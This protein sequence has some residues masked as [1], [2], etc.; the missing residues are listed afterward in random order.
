M[1]R[2]NYEPDAAG[3]APELPDPAQSQGPIPPPVPPHGY[4][5]RDPPFKSTAFSVIL[6]I[7][8]PGLGHIYVGY[9]R[10]AFT[11]ILIM[12]SLITLLAAGDMGGLVPLL[13]IMLGFTYFYQIIDA[14]RRASLYNHVLA[15]GQVGLTA[16]NIELPETNPRFGGGVLIAIGV[17]AL[18]NTL[19]DISLDWLADW[20]PLALIILGG[21]M[22]AKGRETPGKTSAPRD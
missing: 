6:A 18:G 12:A 17:I 1:E 21:W 8:I 9:F 7:I 5:R 3:R 11:I 14:G 15:T 22:V 19:F 13:G 20:W 10:L 4:A 16:E 2:M